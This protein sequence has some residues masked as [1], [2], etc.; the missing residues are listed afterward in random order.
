MAVVGAIKGCASYC[1]YA[2][3]HIL[4]LAA[5]RKCHA[6]AQQTQWLFIAH[7]DEVA[8]GV[9]WVG[10]GL[11]GYW[12]ATLFQGHPLALWTVRR[13]LRAAALAVET[14][15]RSLGSAI[16]DSRKVRKR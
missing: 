4:R 10:V 16:E 5:G 7:R 6:V 3:L 2:V 15:F 13:P 12:R 11:G 1:T 14:T 9:G 8:A